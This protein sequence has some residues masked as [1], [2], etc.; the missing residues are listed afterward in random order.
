MKVNLEGLF[1]NV[2]SEV[3]KNQRGYYGVCLGEVLDHIKSVVAGEHTIAEFAE[4][5]CLSAPTVTRE[6]EE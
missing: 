2:L 3:N 4:H 1:A 5:Y 6:K